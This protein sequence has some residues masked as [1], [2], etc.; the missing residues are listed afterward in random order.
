[1]SLL[2]L[3]IGLAF[4]TSLYLIIDYFLPI[5]EL[6]DLEEN[7]E[8]K[9]EQQTEQ[10]TRQPVSF[11]EKFL[12]DTTLKDVI[13][14]YVQYKKQENRRQTW[15]LVIMTVLF[16]VIIAG[17]TFLVFCDKVQ[18]ESLM[19]MVGT[20]LGFLITIILKLTGIKESIF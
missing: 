19:F 10:I 16:S 4:G 13:E 2:F 1:M 20:V 8:T 9:T 5:K 12:G 11:V 3:F 18:G 6:L 17:M 7:K 15:T 14:Q